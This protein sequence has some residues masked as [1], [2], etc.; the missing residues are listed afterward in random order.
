MFEYHAGMSSSFRI[1]AGLVILALVE[2][3]AAQ[4]YIDPGSG[5]IVFQMIIAA[6]VG[7]VFTLKLFW[8]KLKRLLAGGEAENARLESDTDV[9]TNA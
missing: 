6:I 7:G 5:S 4:A 1:A 9:D 8:K 3:Q 2:P